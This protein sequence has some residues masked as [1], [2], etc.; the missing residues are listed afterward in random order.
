M[1]LRNNGPKAFRE[2]FWPS[3]G[4]GGYLSPTICMHLSGGTSVPISAKKAILFL[5]YIFLLVFHF[6]FAL[7]CFI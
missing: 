5:F 7:H 3:S 2:V 4:P 1:A 6:V